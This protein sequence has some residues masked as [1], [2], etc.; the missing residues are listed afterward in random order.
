LQRKWRRLF[1]DEDAFVWHDPVPRAS[2]S[3]SYR[4]RYP[5]GRGG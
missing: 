3:P 2:P 1:P 5:E 4:P